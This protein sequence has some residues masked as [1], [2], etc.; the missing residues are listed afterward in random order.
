MLPGFVL[1]RLPVIEPSPVPCMLN[2]PAARS[3]RFA[4]PENAPDRFVTVPVF[5]PFSVHVAPVAFSVPVF[6]VSCRLPMPENEPERFVAVPA[7]APLIVHIAFSSFNVPVA[8]S[9]K[10]P[11]PENEPERFDTVPAFGPVIVQVAFASLSV[12]APVSV[13]FSNDVQFTVPL[14]PALA[15]V[16]V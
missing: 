13:M 11:M 7:L 5:A 9:C 2:V 10:V 3:V 6:A 16:I 14:L 1:T 15:P 12:P 4:I 8:V